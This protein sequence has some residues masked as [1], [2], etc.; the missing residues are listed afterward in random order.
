MNQIQVIICINREMSQENSLCSYLK[1]PKMSFFF[2]LQNWR[3]RGQ[4]RSC[5]RGLVLV[6][7][8]RDRERVWKDEYSA[9]TVYVCM[10]IEK[11]DLLEVFQEWEERGMKENGGGSEFKHD[12]FDIL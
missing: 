2:L 1:Q 7:G 5:L 8:G 11:W 10:Q 9:N 6:G 12:I 4:N 3:T